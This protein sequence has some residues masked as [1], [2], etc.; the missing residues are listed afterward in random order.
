MTTEELKQR[1][2]QSWLQ[3]GKPIRAKF[4]ELA[5]LLIRHFAIRKGETLYRLGNIEFYYYYDSHRDII[6]YP[7]NCPPGRWFFHASGVDITFESHVEV[8]DGSKKPKLTKDAYFGGILIRRIEKL[9]PTAFEVFDG[10]MKSCE[11]LFDHFDAF[12]N[13]SGFP[14]LVPYDWQRI[15]PIVPTSRYGLNKDPRKKVKSI[16]SNN[17]VGTDINP[18]D[19]IKEY[20]CF[21]NDPCAYNL[22]G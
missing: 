6:T 17:Y 13:V 19:L 7:R 3:D 12:G 11:E 15:Y 18:E 1:L 10:P 8:P 9:T 2:S 22:K 16:L 4:D 14:S 21:L 20:E 5:E